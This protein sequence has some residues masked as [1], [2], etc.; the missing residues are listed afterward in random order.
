[1]SL[2]EH[3]QKS[4]ERDFIEEKIQEGLMQCRNDKAPRPVGFNMS[5]LHIF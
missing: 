5:F 3:S 2:D 4:L 1:M